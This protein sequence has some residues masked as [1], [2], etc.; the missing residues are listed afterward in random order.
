MSAVSYP[1]KKAKIGHQA[2]CNKCKTYV[3]PT[4]VFYHNEPDTGLCPHCNREVKK[5]KNS[6]RFEDGILTKV[7]SLSIV[8][9]L[10]SL[11]IG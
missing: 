4:V 9:Y 6:S 2:F 5:Y 10:I 7:V 11:F 1:L 3:V 8:V